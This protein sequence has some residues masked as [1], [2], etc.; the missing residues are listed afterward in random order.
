MVQKHN[1]GC[2]GQQCK[3]FAEFPVS[4]IWHGS[5]HKRAM[6]VKLAMASA[7]IS[8]NLLRQKFK[9]NFSKYCAGFS[10]GDIFLVIAGKFIKQVYY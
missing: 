10:P 1:L 6:L 4:C 9:L 3:R 7:H 8:M 5:L 2:K